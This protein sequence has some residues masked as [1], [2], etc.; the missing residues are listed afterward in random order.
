MVSRTVRERRI[1]SKSDPGLGEDDD[2]V[3]DASLDTKSDPKVARVMNA[4]K[5]GI[6]IECY[7]GP[8]PARS[9]CGGAGDG[10]R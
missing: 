5:H 2:I 7:R 8:P 1:V 10:R 9:I 6:P 3:G 4:L